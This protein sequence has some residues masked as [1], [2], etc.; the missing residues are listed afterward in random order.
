M[1]EWL[2][3]ELDNK[4]Y[5]CNSNLVQIKVEELDSL[6]KKINTYLEVHPKLKNKLFSEDH[7]DDRFCRSAK[8]YLTLE[9]E[10]DIDII[11][12]VNMTEEQKEY[13]KQQILQFQAYREACKFI[14]EKAENPF[15]YLDSDLSVRL[16]NLLL[17]NDQDKHLK[18][19]PRL[20]NQ[21]DPKIIIGQGYFDPVSGEKVSE[22]FA[23]MLYKFENVWKDDNVFVKGAKFVIEYVRIQPHIDG[24]KRMALMLLNFILNRNGYSDIYF[25]QNQTEALYNAIKTGIL[26]RDVTDLSLLILE[27]SRLYCEDIIDKIKEHRL[28]N[29]IEPMSLINN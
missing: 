24:N 15:T 14:H 16:H 4:E 7:R 2:T 23:V 8:S 20:R 18:V 3:E 13:D 10:N 5:I 9:G 26:T 25:A 1:A 29:S 21:D 12:S 11:P 27:S 6:I 22:R 28:K 17:M 19:R